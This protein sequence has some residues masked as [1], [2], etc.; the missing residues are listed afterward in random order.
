LADVQ[1]KID[2]AYKLQDDLE[3][4]K[5]NLGATRDTLIDVVQPLNELD[6]RE[7]KQPEIDHILN[8]LGKINTS[9]MVQVKEIMPKNQEIGELEIE[10]MNMLDKNKGNKINEAVDKLKLLIIS[11]NDLGKNKDHALDRLT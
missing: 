8:A 5:E 1:K 7:V 6:E 10:L 4:M 9:L 11:V 2:A 3:S